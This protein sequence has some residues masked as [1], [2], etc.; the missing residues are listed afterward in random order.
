MTEALGMM[1]LLQTV[2]HTGLCAFP[3]VVTKARSA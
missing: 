1:A 3:E 2:G